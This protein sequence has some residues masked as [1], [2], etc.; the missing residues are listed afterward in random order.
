M[1]PLHS[2]IKANRVKM[3]CIKLL[4]RFTTLMA[5]LC[6]AF[7]ELKPTQNGEEDEMKNSTSSFSDADTSQTFRGN[8]SQSSRNFIKPRARFSPSTAPVYTFGFSFHGG[9][10]VI[11]DSFALRI[12]MTSEEP[13]E[14][15]GKFCLPV[16]HSSVTVIKNIN[17]FFLQSNCT[18]NYDQKLSSENESFIN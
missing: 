3:F 13:R 8:R 17:K 4:L 14:R 16:S 10:L 2:F 12:L 1:F 15:N 9:Y 18:V 5:L 7:V 11:P 6:Q